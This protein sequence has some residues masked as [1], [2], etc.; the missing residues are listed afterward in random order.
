LLVHVDK[1]NPSENDLRCLHLNY[2]AY[3]ILVDSLNKD[4]YFAIMPQD[5]PILM[6]TTFGAKFMINMPNLVKTQLLLLH[7]ICMRLTC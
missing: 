1:R 5:D 2:Q 4:I 6:L 3:D 7:R